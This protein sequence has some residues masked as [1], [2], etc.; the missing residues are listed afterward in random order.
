MG[1]IGKVRL[2]LINRWANGF[3][4]RALDLAH[5]IETHLPDADGAIRSSVPLLDLTDPSLSSDKPRSR[6]VREP[7]AP[8][9]SVSTPRA[10]S[11]SLIAA[12][13]ESQYIST[14]ARLIG[15]TIESR[16]PRF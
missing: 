2:G 4:L 15:V 10:P 11:A 9:R 3:D 6:T 13:D 5:R 16:F 1:Y 7:F 12:F 8:V 14:S